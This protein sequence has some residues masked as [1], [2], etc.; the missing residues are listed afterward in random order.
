MPSCPPLRTVLLNYEWLPTDAFERLP[1]IGYWNSNRLDS[2]RL[3]RIWE[4][5][6]H[7]L[8]I[9]RQYGVQATLVPVGY[10][11]FLTNADVPPLDEAQ[12]DIDVL[13]FGE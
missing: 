6:Y 7:N 5:S 8:Q 12:K 10:S 3:Y 9:W 4:Y 1:T 13:F 11:P 2:F